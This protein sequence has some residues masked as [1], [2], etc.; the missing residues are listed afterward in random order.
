MKAGMKMLTDV[1]EEAHPVQAYPQ[2]HALNILAA[3]FLDKVLSNDAQ[4]YV[5]KGNFLWILQII[6]LGDVK[7]ALSEH[8]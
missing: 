8:S 7:I 2:T 3:V 6:H 4:P 1:L 5:V